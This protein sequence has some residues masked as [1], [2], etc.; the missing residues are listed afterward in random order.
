MARKQPPAILVATKAGTLRDPVTRERYRFTRGQQFPANH[1][2]V[3]LAPQLF[4]A[5][6]KE[7]R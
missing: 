6:S 3:A 4:R 1:P 2:L 7:G 5:V